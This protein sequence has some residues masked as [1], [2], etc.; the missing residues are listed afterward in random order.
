MGLDSTPC[1]FITKKDNA[2]HPI[3]DLCGL[4][5]YLKVLPFHVL[6]TTEVIS[7][8]RPGY[9]F[10]SIDLEKGYFHVPIVAYHPRFLHF[11]SQGHHYQVRVLPF[12]LSLSSRVFSQF[13]AAALEPV[14]ANG[15]RVVTYLDDTHSLGHYSIFSGTSQITVDASCSNWTH[16]PHQCAGVTDRPSLKYK[17]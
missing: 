6:T 10:T 1:L 3:L 7:M 8:I 11:A 14:Q 2:F 13:V 16:T 4:N 12:S 17:D 15:V 5:R 9:W